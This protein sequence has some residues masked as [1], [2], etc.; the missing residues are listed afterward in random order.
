M[1]WVNERAYVMDSNGHYAYYPYILASFMSLK[2]VLGLIS[3]AFANT[4]S[5]PH[6]HILTETRKSG[7]HNS[8]DWFVL[9]RPVDCCLHDVAHLHI[10]FV[11]QQNWNPLNISESCLWLINCHCLSAD[12]LIVDER[13]LFILKKMTNNHMTIIIFDKSV[14]IFTEEL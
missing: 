1:F 10:L 5:H 14:S 3:T 8:K 2:N 11:R 9:S 12:T 7:L 13:I 6:T 4:R